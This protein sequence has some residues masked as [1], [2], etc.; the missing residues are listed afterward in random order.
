MRHSL[1]CVFL[2]ALLSVLLGSCYYAAP[3]YTAW[4]LSPRVRDSLLFVEQHQY[5]VNYNFL[6]VADSLSVCPDSL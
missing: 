1:S 4:D 5:S 2:G 6:V 3:D